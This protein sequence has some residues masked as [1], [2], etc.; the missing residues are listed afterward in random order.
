M[1]GPKAGHLKKR[2]F[3]MSVS[4]GEV[5]ILAGELSPTFSYIMAY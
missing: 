4:D 5:I 1:L 2:A 3:S